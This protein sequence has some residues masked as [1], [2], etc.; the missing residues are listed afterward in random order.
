MCVYPIASV[1]MLCLRPRP[2]RGK[3]KPAF[4]VDEI[5]M[6]VDAVGMAMRSLMRRT[7]EMRVSPRRNE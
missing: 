6:D 3:Q 2:S 7:S 1:A 5:G 4:H